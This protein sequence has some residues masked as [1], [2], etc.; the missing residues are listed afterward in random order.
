MRAPEKVG[1]GQKGRDWA[2]ERSESRRERRR[3]MGWRK[4]MNSL[5]HISELGDAYAARRRRV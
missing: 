5:P 2:N 3:R 1:E 4:G